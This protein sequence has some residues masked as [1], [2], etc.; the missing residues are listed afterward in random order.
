M[1]RGRGASAEPEERSNAFHTPAPVLPT[2]ALG[3]R[4]WHRCFTP[5]CRRLGSAGLSPAPAGAVTAADPAASGTL[6]SRSAALAHSDS[7]GGPIP[8]RRTSQG[9]RACLDQRRTVPTRRRAPRLRLWRELRPGRAH[10]S[11][12]PGQASH[13]PMACC[14]YR[15][16]GR[17]PRCRPGKA[18]RHMG[19]ANGEEDRPSRNRVRQH[20][21]SVAPNPITAR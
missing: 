3:R 9:R 18:T 13:L 14:L 10:L 12:R 11:C 1:K 5:S 19:L 21:A 4:S 17:H 8:W 6:G 7:V 2:Y 15:L 16:R 20:G